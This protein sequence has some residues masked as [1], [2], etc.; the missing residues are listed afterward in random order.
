MPPHITCW[1]CQHTW[2]NLVLGSL[3]RRLHLQRVTLCNSF[4][5]ESQICKHCGCL[6]S[7][8]QVEV[9]RKGEPHSWADSSDSLFWPL[10]RS[11]CWCSWW[12]QGAVCSANIATPTQS[13]VINARNVFG[14]KSDDP[15]SVMGLLQMQIY[16][17]ANWNG[18][19][20]CRRVG[21]WHAY[22]AQ[23]I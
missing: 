21:T 9:S 14:M 15:R 2:S 7:W 23:K 5:V 4:K 8:S 17:N 6:W 18:I 1:P 3:S 11:W 19:K 10:E 20:Q 22:W 16:E 13:V 12:W